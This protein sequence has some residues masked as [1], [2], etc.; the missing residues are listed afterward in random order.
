MFFN[1]T[2]LIFFQN[3]LLTV[4]HLF[5]YRSIYYL[6]TLHT[7]QCFYFILHRFCGTCSCLAVTACFEFRSSPYFTLLT[8]LISNFTGTFV[9]RHR[10]GYQTSLFLGT[11]LSWHSN[12]SSQPVA[13][14]LTLV[15]FVSV[16]SLFWLF[17]LGDVLECSSWR[18]CPTTCVAFS[19]IFF[20]VHSNYS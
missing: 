13:R 7:F 10:H 14:D 12:S 11:C 15:C 5:I 4:Q 16:A 9:P 1:L 3:H 2:R 8:V 6:Q 20:V 17:S 19:S 18:G